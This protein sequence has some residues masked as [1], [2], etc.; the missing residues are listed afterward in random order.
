L[1]L[2]L[3]VAGVVGLIVEHRLTAD[4]A[5]GMIGLGAGLL[6]LATLLRAVFHWR[7]HRQIKQVA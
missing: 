1:A 4:M 3:V 5:Y 7:Y 6:I 2:L